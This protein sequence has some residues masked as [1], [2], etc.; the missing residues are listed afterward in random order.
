MYSNLISFVAAILLYELYIPRLE[1]GGLAWGEILVQTAVVV[2]AFYGLVRWGFARW[3]RRNRSGY[4]S[5]QALALLH[6]SLLQRYTVLAVVLYGAVLYLFHWKALC[7]VLVGRGG[8]QSISSLLGIA[9]FILLLLT[10]WAASYPS[11]HRWV[12]GKRETGYGD[13]RGSGVTGFLSSQARFN[14]AIVLPWLGVL[15]A[16]DLISVLFPD[17]AKHIQEDLMWAVAALVI[18][19]LALAWA[20]PVLVVKLWRCR[21]L[22]EG[23]RHEALKAFFRRHSFGYR[24]IVLWDLFQGRWSTA[25]ILGLFP[26]S[27][28]VLITPALFS[29]LDD[30]EMEAVMAHEMGHARHLHM[31]FYLAFML[32]LTLLFDLCLQGTTRLVTLGVLAM[33]AKGFPLEA[34]LGRAEAGLTM[35]SLLVALPSVLVVV[36][37][38]RFGFGLFSRNFERQS[39]VHAL[40]TQGTAEPI[41][42]SLEKVSGPSPMARFLPNWH[43]FSI[44]E[45]IDFLRLCQDRPEVMIRHHRKVRLMVV[46]YLLGLLALGAVT[47]AWRTNQWGEGWTLGL[48][49][50]IIERR[51]EDA[52]QDPRLWLELGSL[53]FRRGDMRAA[54]EGLRRCIALDPRNA[55]AL[56]NLAWLY[57]TSPKG[58]FHRPEEALELALEA[59]RLRPNS[60]H[61]LDTLAEAYFVNGLYRD[62]LETGLKALAYATDREAYYR[63]Q[64]DRFRKALPSLK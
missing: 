51:I 10:E 9:P 8:L 41:I 11:F 63:A 19:L 3:G 40:E 54:E 59:S 14:L 22:P 43:H 5:A 49:Q 50:S 60:P 33:E 20:F 56:N 48:M 55:E 16:V 44:Q 47:M 7:A 30:Q 29:S 27:R 13:S 57:A 64:V 15:I 37:Y 17:I 42:R 34:W 39:D 18:F 62:A 38:F 32:G 53:A 45:R 2:V 4:P 52:P 1:A 24:R 26:R 12:E 28:Y 25:G 58:E 6:S 23:P 35:V 21:P 31:P 61:I 36:L 46:C